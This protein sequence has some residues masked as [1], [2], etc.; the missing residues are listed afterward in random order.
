MTGY[1][2]FVV[3]MA[4][5]AQTHAMMTVFYVSCC[6]RLSKGLKTAISPPVPAALSLRGSLAPIA[7]RAWLCAHIGAIRTHVFPAETLHSF[8]YH[9]WGSSIGFLL[10]THRGI[11]NIKG[12]PDWRPRQQLRIPPRLPSTHFSPTPSPHVSHS[13]LFFP[14]HFDRRF[15][16]HLKHS[17][18]RLAKPGKSCMANGCMPHCSFRSPYSISIR[19]ILEGLDS[20]ALESQCAYFKAQLGERPPVVHR[21]QLGPWPEN[22]PRPRSLPYMATLD[23]FRRS[24]PPGA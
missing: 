21:R 2:A 15:P 18:K 5:G 4:R 13:R 23:T 16:R 10:R 22:T 17:I 9:M 24:A 8:M 6:A 14:Y 7:L 3:C 19:Y 1:R 11:S 12:R 20:R